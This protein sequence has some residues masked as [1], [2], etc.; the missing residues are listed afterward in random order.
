MGVTKRALLLC[1]GM[2]LPVHET[3]LAGARLRLAMVTARCMGAMQVRPLLSHFI[4]TE[5]C[6]RLEVGVGCPFLGAAIGFGRRC[7][8][9]PARLAGPCFWLHMCINDGEMLR[10]IPTR[11]NSQG[12]VAVPAF[13]WQLRNWGAG[14]TMSCPGNSFLRM[15]YVCCLL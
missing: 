6:S 8:A 5:I 10:R 4:A 9:N 11:P 12:H 7:R 2:A 3:W 15:P 1:S 14:V 13:G